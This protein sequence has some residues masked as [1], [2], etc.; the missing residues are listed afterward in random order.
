V[1]AVLGLVGLGR[2]PQDLGD[3][4]LELGQ[5]AV[6]PAGGVGG[7]LGAVQR[8]QAQPDQPGRLAQPQRLDQE[9]GQR[10]LVAGAEAGDGHVVGGLVADQ[11][12]KGDVLVAG[13]LDLSG[14]AHPD[15]I[16]VQQHP[17]SVFGS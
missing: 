1:L 15:G 5:G 2:L 3:L 11:H 10:L 8:D 14:G 4:L 6:G 12:P 9:A 16:G 13:P 7:H 17:S